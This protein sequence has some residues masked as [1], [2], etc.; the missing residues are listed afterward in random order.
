VGR[1]RGVAIVSNDE[2]ARRGEERRR[3]EEKDNEQGRKE[4]RIVTH[5]GL[6]RVTD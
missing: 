5:S 3:W 6:R 1:N 2:E 4:D